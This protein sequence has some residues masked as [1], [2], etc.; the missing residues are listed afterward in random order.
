MYHL[1]DACYLMLL[2]Y[3]TISI[4]V[5]TPTGSSSL[6]QVEQPGQGDHGHHGNAQGIAHPTD[7][8]LLERNRQH[9]VKFAQEHGIN[10]RQNYNRDAPR[11]ATR[12]GRVLCDVERQLTKLLERVQA[13]TLNEGLVVGKDYKG[14]RRLGRNPLN[15][16]LGAE[17][18]SR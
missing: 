3:D 14:D 6:A 18:L 13:T 9:M 11:L 5:Q 1:A 10:L 7:N 2:L 16:A 17:T 15:G 8:R 4:G 12:V